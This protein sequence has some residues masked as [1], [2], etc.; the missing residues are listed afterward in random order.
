MQLVTVSAF[1]GYKNADLQMSPVPRDDVGLLG[2]ASFPI[3]SCHGAVE[4]EWNITGLI[5]EVTLRVSE[6][7][8]TV[9]VNLKV[10]FRLTRCKRRMTYVKG[11]GRTCAKT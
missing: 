6:P 4:V 1:R 11:G 10:L 8:L 7:I 9:I 2:D 3:Y 5:E